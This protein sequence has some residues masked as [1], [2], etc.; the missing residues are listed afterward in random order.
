MAAEPSFVDIV[1]TSLSLLKSLPNDT[2]AVDRAKLLIPD[3]DSL[4]R[5][6]S[7]IFY[8]DIGDSSCLLSLDDHFIA[9]ESVDE[10]LAR[11][12]VLIRLGLKFADLRNLG[13]NLGQAPITTVRHNLQRYT[14]QQFLLE[15]FA[16]AEDA[17]A[18]EFSVALNL[19]TLRDKQE[20]RVLSPTMAYLCKLPSLVIHNDA[21]FSSDDFKGICHTSIGGK[22][23]RT[24]TIGE[25][26]L[27]ALTMYHFADVC[28]INYSKF[29]YC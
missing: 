17:K 14:N 21:H 24:D 4:L 15:F 3:T 7:R 11:K 29:E 9:H 26:G 27:G 12:L 16:N 18:T 10:S 28:I 22:G 5:P 20:M 13:P 19:V 23:G 25:F 1:G 8:N 2:T 6:S